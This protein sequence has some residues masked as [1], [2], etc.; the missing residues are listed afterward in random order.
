MS[1]PPTLESLQEELNVIKA[2]LTKANAVIADTGRHVL[3]L[4]VNG[5]R[6]RLGQ[7]DLNSSAP[8]ESYAYD[9]A[10]AASVTAE[11]VTELVTELQSQ[12]DLQEERSIRRSANAFVIKDTDFI[13]PLPTT[14]SSIPTYE[15]GFPAT[16]DDFNQLDHEGIVTWLK[17]Y[18]L[19]PPDEAEMARLRR[20]LDIEED[21]EEEETVP[22]SESLSEETIDFEHGELSKAEQDTLFDNLARFLGLRIRRTTGVW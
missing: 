14:D 8:V 7:L 19:L 5:E 20:L 6:Q 12:L 1:T 3:S 13:A 18:E 10:T 9:S 17:Y 2:Q 21:D 15:E 16:L 11:D 22:V 4:Q